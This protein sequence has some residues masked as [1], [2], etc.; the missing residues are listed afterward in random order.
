MLQNG[1]K[2]FEGEY[3]FADEANKAPNKIETRFGTAS[4]GKLFLSLNY[5]K[6]LS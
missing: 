4:V 6:I 5:Q 1:N 3:G 2:I